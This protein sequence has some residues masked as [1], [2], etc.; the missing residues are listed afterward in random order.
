MKSIIAFFP[1]C[2]WHMASGTPLPPQNSPDVLP[3]EPL[4]THAV[5][6]IIT[7]PRASAESIQAATRKARAG[8]LGSTSEAKNVTLPNHAVLGTH[9]FARGDRKEDKDKDDKDDD[10]KTVFKSTCHANASTFV[11]NTRSTSPLAADCSALVDQ[12]MSQYAN[13]SCTSF[14]FA[15]NNNSNNNNNT[16]GNNGT[17]GSGSS[18]KTTTNLIAAYASCGFS[19]TVDS[20]AVGSTSVGVGDVVSVI[21]EVVRRF[22]IDYAI[23]KRDGGVVN[24]TAGPANSTVDERVSGAGAFECGGGG[25]GNGNGTMGRGTFVNWAVV[26]T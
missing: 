11:D 10:N 14:G 3:R 21:R 2:L 23:H 17:N 13:Q 15:P 1:L 5:E 24:G 19:M 18:S 26:H 20:A 9:L 12:L 22:A 25:N 4:L 7:Y 6:P 8:L 16:A